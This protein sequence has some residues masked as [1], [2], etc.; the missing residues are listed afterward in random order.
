MKYIG[1]KFVDAVPMAA[2][3][4]EGKGYRVSGN[5]GDGYEVQILVS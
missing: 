3:V 2:D 5:K 4:A 1:I